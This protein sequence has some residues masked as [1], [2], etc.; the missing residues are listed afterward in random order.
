MVFSACIIQLLSMLPQ[1]RL[2]CVHVLGSLE[3]VE[4]AGR[5][6]KTLTPH[7]FQQQIAT[8][9]NTTSLNEL[10]HMSYCNTLRERCAQVINTIPIHCHPK[11]NRCSIRQVTAVYCAA[12]LT[13]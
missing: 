8:V 2:M 12:E 10:G 11:V 3:E 4:V 6:N 1:S 5:T 13:S 7:R 9:Q